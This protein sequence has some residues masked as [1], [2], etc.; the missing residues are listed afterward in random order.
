[1]CQSL[2]EIAKHCVRENPNMCILFKQ[3]DKTLKYFKETHISGYMDFIEFKQFCDGA[4]SKKHGF[5][6]V[7]LWKNVIV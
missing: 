1:L 3:D 6:I 5:V 7:N 2:H 4:W